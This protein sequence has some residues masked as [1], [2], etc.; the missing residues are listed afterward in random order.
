MDARLRGTAMGNQ[1]G[2]AGQLDQD[3]REA[4]QR[5]QL[6]RGIKVL[7]VEDDPDT[8]VIIA[9]TL[10]AHGARVTAVEN[11]QQGLEVLPTLLPH[12]L[13][14]DIGL[15][16]EDGYS[17][18][19]KVR[20]LPPARGGL[21]PAAA[22]TAFTSDRDKGKAWGSGFEEHVGKPTDPLTIVVLVANLARES[23]YGSVR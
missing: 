8:R 6:L 2:A 13:L 22:L 12:V 21:V 5:S 14:S 15:P 17:F 23:P 1:A 4:A 11:G 9:M 18:I 19:Q 3:V 16:N 10:E 20:A 7:L